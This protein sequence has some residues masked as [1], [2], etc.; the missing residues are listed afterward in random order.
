MAGWGGRRSDRG[1]IPYAATRAKTRRV[2]LLP[3]DAYTR[4]LLMEIPEISRTLG[5]AVYRREIEALAARFRGVDLIEQAT[6]ANLARTYREVLG[7]C[8]GALREQVASYLR[9]WDLWNLKTVLR[10]KFSGAAGEEI[11]VNLVPA[12]EFSPALME[13]LLAA[14]SVAEVVEGL[15]GTSYHEPLTRALAESGQTEQAKNLMPLENRLDRAYYEWLLSG[16]PVTRADALFRDF[17][18]LEVDVVNLRTLLRLKAD[19]QPPERIQEFLLPGGKH[20]KAEILRRLAEAPSA[21]VVGLLRGTPLAAALAP[22]EQ[23]PQA[24]AR[25]LR[26]LEKFHL[27]K[28]RVFG[29]A[30]PLSALPVLDLFLRK[31]NEVDN[32][33]IIARGKETG[34]REEEIREQLVM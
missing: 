4:M 12:G 24:T 1:N 10:G 16:R 6:Y 7:F 18:R 9:R 5:E 25:A 32:I 20:L 21:E 15:R 3:G 26:S 23:D 14:R 34:M 11:R 29:H 31:K 2:Q 8:R 33:R 22:L 19:G 17:V 28:A 13:E 27:A 30:Y